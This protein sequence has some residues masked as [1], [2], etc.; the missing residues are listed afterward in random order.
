MIE[1]ADL[2]KSYRIGARTLPV[3]RDVCHLDAETARATVR[4]A[5]ETLLEAT[6]P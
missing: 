2:N 5:A 4:W 3:L 6:F 1:I